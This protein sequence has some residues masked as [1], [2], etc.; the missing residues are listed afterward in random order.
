M[1]QVEDAELVWAKGLPTSAVALA[2]DVH[3][4]PG[5]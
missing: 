1:L 3:L 4:N 2:S 5:P